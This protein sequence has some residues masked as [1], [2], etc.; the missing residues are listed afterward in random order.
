MRNKFILNLFMFFLLLLF[1]FAMPA[2]AAEKALLPTSPQPTKAT[3]VQLEEFSIN[4]NLFEEYSDIKTIYNV[5]NTSNRKITLTLKLPVSSVLKSPNNDTAP[6]LT[7]S[8]KQFKFYK[9]QNS[10]Y[11]EIPFEPNEKLILDFSYNSSYIIEDKDMLTAGLRWPSQNLWSGETVKSDLKFHFNEINPGQIIDIEPKS[12]KIIADTLSWSWDGLP[13]SESVKIHADIISEITRWEA[14]LSEEEREL[15][16]QFLSVHNYQAASFFYTNKY[17]AAQADEQP[18]LRVGQAY[19]LEKAGKHEEAL[20]IWNELYDDKSLSSH[21]YW[22]LGKKYKLQ[23]SNLNNLYEQVRELQVHPLLQQ[24]LANQLPSNLIKHSPP[25]VILT[26][27]S[28][29]KEKNGLLI[30]GSFSDPDGDIDKITLR[31]RC[32]DNPYVE[33]TFDLKPFEYT[34]NVSFFIPMDKSMQKVYY[35]FVVTDSTQNTINSEQKEVFFL[36]NEI[37]S[38]TYPLLGAKLVL[39]DYSIAEHDK[40]YKWFKSYLKMANEAKFIPL[41]GKAP[42]FIFLGKPNDFIASYQGPLFLMYTPA[43]FSPNTTKLYVHRYFLSYW[44]GAGWEQLTDEELLK[45]G[46]AL[47]L[48][49]GSFVR[50]IKYLKHNDQTHFYELLEFIGAGNTWEQ[51]INEV[52]QMSAFEINVKAY[53]YTY[54]N[55]VLAVVIILL[56]AWLGKNGYISKLIKS[57]R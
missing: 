45:F 32:E 7:I 12:F 52:Y 10:Y 33:N 42:Y 25:E 20:V 4:V 26:K 39:G 24:W 38:T 51:G 36:T 50:I 5:F 27:A 37:Q 21:V 16:H 46:D 49:Q 57:L 30:K 8:E 54:G 56:F 15:L 3:V 17:E 29:D 19:Y 31:Y 48:G 14:A 2:T 13:D 22:Q 40:V 55:N 9:K 6:E 11:W 53:W 23:S 41:G 34:Q 1:Y 47:L 44:Y 43:P 18:F 35:E 28:V